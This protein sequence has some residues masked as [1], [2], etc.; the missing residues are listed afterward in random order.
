MPAARC[1]RRRK[2][3]QWALRIT[4]FLIAGCSLLVAYRLNRLG[5]LSSTNTLS[6]QA[7][8][9][10]SLI[11]L[12]APSEDIAVDPLS[13]ALIL[14]CGGLQEGGRGQTLALLRTGSDR[15]E[16]I[17][18]DAPDDFHPH[19]IDSV[20]LDDQRSRLFVV[21]HRQRSRPTIEIFDLYASLKPPKASHVETIDSIFLE[22]PNDIAAYDAESF[23]V[24]NNPDQT[25]LSQRLRMF[26]GVTRG[27]ILWYD[28]DGFRRFHSNGFTNGIAL[29]PER[30]RL[31]V[32]HT[33]TGKI[34]AFYIAEKKNLS[35]KVTT[36]LYKLRFD[37]L[38]VGD[39][40]SILAAAHTDLLALAGHRKNQQNDSGWEAYRIDPQS[41]QATKIAGDDGST[42]SGISVAAYWNG[43]YYFGSVGDPYLLKAT[44]LSPAPAAP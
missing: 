20:Q 11:E 9:R 39:N 44:P 41:F 32:A 2:R 7:D 40:G 26:L 42:I 31:Y 21:N 18:T 37:N 25:K 35:T 27:E 28:A 33:L 10:T 29:S 12:P 17:Q 30:D 36:Y 6:S 13:G 5:F 8:V 19:G 1:K 16:V 24:T 38:F 34:S 14:S 22:F 3:W 43:A 23:Y 4:L 15:P